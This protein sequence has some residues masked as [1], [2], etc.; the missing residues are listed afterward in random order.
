VAIP[1]A[2]HG[3]KGEEEV[4]TAPQGFCSHPF[5]GPGKVLGKGLSDAVQDLLHTS[6]LQFSTPREDVTEPEMKKGIAHAVQ[7]LFAL[8]RLFFRNG[9]FS[10]GDFEIGQHS[11][12][13]VGNGL[14][15]TRGVDDF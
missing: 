14:S 6:H 4:H 9:Q 2:P 10:F 1:P 8:E 5:I 11:Q 13:L 3:G 15:Q 12:I 7:P